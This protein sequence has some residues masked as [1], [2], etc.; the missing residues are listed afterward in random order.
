MDEFDFEEP[1]EKRRSSTGTIILNILTI[2]L[3]LGV[4]CVACSFVSVFLF[5]YIP[6]NP[7]PP[8]TLPVAVGFPT[9]TPTPR[10]VL[11]PTW[12]PLPTEPPTETPVP[13]PTATLPPTP[14][15]FTLE[16][17][18]EAAGTPGAKTPP[19]MPFVVK[20]GQPLAIQ[21]I[22]YPELACSWMG[23]AGRVF[24]LRNSPVTGQQVQ[25]GGALA[26]VPGIGDFNITL[27]GLAPQYGAGYYEFKLADKPITSNGTLWLQLLDQAGLPMSEKIFFNTS[28][29]CDKNLI[30]VD[31]EQVR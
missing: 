15:F 10:E 11:P 27:T 14:T 9:I 5:P 17:P 8:P 26:G 22:A 25:L 2:L 30:L 3:L 21:N 12:T 23:V 20:A 29:Q 4:V 1:K 24:D 18:T 7:F 13:R 28:D 6:L 19:G 31:F 16:T